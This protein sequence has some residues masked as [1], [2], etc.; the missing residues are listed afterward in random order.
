MTTYSVSEAFALLKSL[1]ITSNEESVRRW[2]RT[3]KLKD[4]QSSKKEGWRIREEDIQQ[5]ID[6]RLSDFNATI[7]ANNDASNE[8]SINKTNV[9][10]EEIREHMWYQIVQ[11]NV[12]EG[13]IEIKKSR[14]KECID[15][16]GYSN[17]FFIYCWNQLNQNNRGH[18]ILRVPYLLDAFLYDS[19]RIKMDN[20]YEMLEEKVLFALIEHLR[21]QK[22]NNKPS[23]NVNLQR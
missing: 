17:E 22:K 9:V 20:N 1:K 15:Y 16:N 8:Q 2:L 11:R 10:K 3:G 12:F 23:K 6:E 19:K 18:A 4:Y 5:F 21:L 13:F 14:L 7:V